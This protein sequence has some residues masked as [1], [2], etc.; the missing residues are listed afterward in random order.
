MDDTR[1]A[2]WRRR[3]QAINPFAVARTRSDWT[4]D[5]LQFAGALGFW[6][7][8]LV[9]DRADSV[10]AWFW[11]I[12]LVLGLLACLVLW[13]SRRYPTFV[14]ALLIVP[15]TLSYTAGA[16][17]IIGVYRMASLGT[18]RKTLLLT[19][20]HLALAIPYHFVAPIA[21][22]PWVAYLIM[23]SLLYILATTIGLLVR[24]RRQVVQGLR[25]QARLDRERYDAELTSIRRDE[26]EGIAREMHD[27]LAHRISLLSVHAG[28]LEFRS[29]ASETNGDR[30][31]TPTEIAEAARIIRENAHLAVEDLREVLSVL[32]DD[33]STGP[34]LGSG[35][36]QP[37]LDDVPHLVE[38]ATRAGQRVELSFDRAAI[39]EL[40]AS[41]QRTVYRVVQ[42]GLT[43]ARK[44]APQT[45]VFVNVGGNHEGVHVQ[46][47][48]PVAVGVTASEIPGALAG[49]AGLA[50]RV[51]IDGGT[52]R[53]GV[54]EGVFSLECDI[55]RGATA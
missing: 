18:P 7:P 54:S 35:R 1:A 36:A 44:H 33:E 45:R 47:S 17:V 13:W 53:H 14:G 6:I 30:A 40:R 15:G 23:V 16:A 32:R 11:P 27:V 46:V 51:S 48:N 22:V 43:N 4:V 42:E 9:G 34:A 55:P 39:G 31:M 20:L 52:L 10:G 19:A 37:D 49:V 2:A 24:A 41:V 29:Q 8:S 25:E 5:A 38:E 21:G 28:A 3:A 50:E 12:D 26:R